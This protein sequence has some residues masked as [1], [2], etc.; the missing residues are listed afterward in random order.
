M[1][2]HEPAVVIVMSDLFATKVYFWK[3]SEKFLPDEAISMTVTSVLYTVYPPSK[4]EI[5][6]VYLQRF[7]MLEHAPHENENL[8]SSL[9][10]HKLWWR[11]DQN[12]FPLSFVFGPVFLLKVFPVYKQLIVLKSRF[13]AP[14]GMQKNTLTRREEGEREHRNPICVSCTMKL[15]RVEFCSPFTY[16]MYCWRVPCWGF[17]FKSTRARKINFNKL[18]ILNELLHSFIAKFS[19]SRVLISWNIAFYLHNDWPIS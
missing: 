13:Q 5:T 18:R 14:R 9:I 2:V 17:V 7:L 15:Y 19:I 16:Y 3:I 8:S 10:Y 1:T 12:C 6:C 11:Q 4:S